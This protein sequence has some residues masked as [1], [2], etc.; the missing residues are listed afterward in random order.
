[1]DK[2]I[3]DKIIEFVALCKK[4]CVKSISLF[5]SAAKNEINE[6]NE[7]SDI[8]FL[9]EFSDD[10]QLLDYADNYFSLIEGLELITGRKIDLLTVKSLK[11]PILKEEIYKSK[12]DL[13]AA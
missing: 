3:S 2:G 11:N 5:G 13:Y 1:M 10:L 6:I 9:V 7:H 4:H 12:I 8:D